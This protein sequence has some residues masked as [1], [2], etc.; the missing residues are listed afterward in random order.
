MPTGTAGRTK[1]GYRLS[2]RWHYV[3]GIDFTDWVLLCANVPEEDARP[4]FFA[5][6]RGRSAWC[7]PGTASACGPPA[8]H[9]V[10][11]DDVFVPAH[12]SFARSEMESGTNSWSR[13]PVH[14]IPF[15]AIGATT[16]AVPAVGAAEGARWRLPSGC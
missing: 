2:G 1:N 11:V 13:L 12:L 15:Q 4:R 16:F 14:N 10:V 6:P 5:L 7:S 3:S 9:T 8:A